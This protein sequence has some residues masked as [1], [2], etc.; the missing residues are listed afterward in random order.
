MVG[1]RALLAPDGS[2]VAGVKLLPPL[3]QARLVHV[4]KRA[5]IGTVKSCVSFLLQANSAEGRVVFCVAL[6]WEHTL[7][8][9]SS[10]GIAPLGY[11]S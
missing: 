1:R 7:S 8:K 2:L 3:S 5:R 4:G 6:L 9:G 10:I 11:T